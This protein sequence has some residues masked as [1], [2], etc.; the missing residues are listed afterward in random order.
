MN[1]GKFKTIAKL[2]T[3]CSS[4][5]NRSITVQKLSV[6]AKPLLILHFFK[7]HI[8]FSIFCIISIF[9]SGASTLNFLDIFPSK[10]SRN[11]WCN[12]LFYARKFL[13]Q[14][15]LDRDWGG[16]R[17]ILVLTRAPALFQ[18]TK[19]GFLG[20]Q[21]F[22]NLHGPLEF[23]FF[24][25]IDGSWGIIILANI[26]SNLLYFTRLFANCCSPESK[27]PVARVDLT[28]A[29]LQHDLTRFS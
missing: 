18:T 4:K 11:I 2:F 26:V 25:I 15:S 20:F 6:L 24:I 16:Q 28:R 9:L 3:Y 27:P 1:H 21:Q 10:T 12:I 7:I 29:P 5:R 17:R 13:M 19:T 23:V 14:G 8:Q 22:Q